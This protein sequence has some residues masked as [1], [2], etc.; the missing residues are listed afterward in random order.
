MDL[1]ET[2]FESRYCFIS[3]HKVDK[4]AEHLKYE[5]SDIVNIFFILLLGL[6]FSYWDEF[7]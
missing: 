5:R 4:A 6:Y 2:F 3:L 7:K 1:R